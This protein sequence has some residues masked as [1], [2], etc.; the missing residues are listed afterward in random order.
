MEFWGS[1]YIYCRTYYFVCSSP[2]GLS[3]WY[4][5]SEAFLSNLPLHIYP[6][7]RRNNG[8]NLF[9]SLQPKPLQGWKNERY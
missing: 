8:S 6:K 7:P 3:D 4:R 9:L 5:R 2:V 1:N